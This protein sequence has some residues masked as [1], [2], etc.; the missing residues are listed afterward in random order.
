MSEV[1][2]QE[3]SINQPIEVT[4]SNILEYCIQNNFGVAAWRSPSSSVINIL[5]DFSAGILI[6]DLT[7]EKSNP[8]FL[9]SPFDVSKKKIF[10]ENELHIQW[11]NEYKVQTSKNTLSEG[12]LK[13]I[14]KVKIKPIKGAVKP[15]SISN[16]NENDFNFLVSKAI[17]EIKKGTFS[18][19]VPSRMKTIAFENEIDLGN[20]FK[21]LVDAYPNAFVSLTYTPYSGVWMGA[22]PEL[23]ISTSGNTFKTVAL[24]GTLKFDPSK[25]LVEIAWTQKEIEE[26]ALVSRYII[27]C[28]KKIRLREFDEN[29]P[30]TIQ[31][32]NLIHLKTEF[33][34]NMKETNFPELGSTMLKLLHPTS[35]VCGMP[36]ESSYLY[37]NENEAYDREYFTGH[38]GPVN[39]ENST[40]IFVNLRCMKVEKNQITLFAGAGVTEDSQPEKEWLE[41]E[42]KM[43]TILNVIDPT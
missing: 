14:N 43:N 22:T 28:F 42:M 27:N 33:I 39:I 13:F 37:I 5:V 40:N 17:N 36:L 38:L 12:L 1:S 31:A 11:N 2:K 18:K 24:A 32:G 20:H 35:A 7:I 23:L 16:S 9:F 26:Q 41:T 34:V 25:S 6:D 3:V 29:G 21:L 4:V 19:V 8:G 30:K 10:L 15:K